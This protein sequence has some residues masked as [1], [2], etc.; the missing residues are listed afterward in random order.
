MKGKTFVPSKSKIIRIFSLTMLVVFLNETFFPTVAFALTGGPS[1][2]EVQSFEPVGTSNMV[3]LS[4]GDFTYNIPLM[5]VDG[6]PINIAYHSGITMDQEASWVGLG[7]NLNPGVINRNMR[8]IPDDFNGESIEK[9]FNMKPNTTVTLNTSAGAEVFGLQFLTL[10]FSLGIK[11]NN[12]NGIGL[13]QGVTAT[14]DSKEG[15]NTPYTLGLGLSSSTDDGLTITPSA[16]FSTKAKL[17]GQKDAVI[18]GSVGCSFNSRAGLSSLSISTSAKIQERQTQKKADTKEQESASKDSDGKTKAFV[19]NG[20]SKPKKIKENLKSFLA[21]Q[22]ANAKG[23]VTHPKFSSSFD[24]GTPT[25]TPNIE[26]SMKHFSITG[27]FT[28]GGEVFGVDGVLGIGGSFSQQKLSSP[29][30]SRKSFGYLYTHNGQQ[31]DAILDFNREKDGIYSANTRNLPITSFTSDLLSVSGQGVGGSYRFFRSDVGYVFDTKS[32]TSSDGFSVGAEIGVGNTAH[33]GVDLSVN[34]VDGH[35]GKWT[36]ENRAISKLIFKNQTADPF[37]ESAY[38]KEANEKSVNSD[39]AF[40]ANTGGY[41]PVR[42]TIDGSTRYHAKLNDQLIDP[43]GNVTTL[44]SSNT[45]KKRDKRNQSLTYLTNSEYNDFAVEPLTINGSV[46]PNHISEITALG[47]DG[48]RYIYG[49]PLYNTYQK[50]V[51]FSVGSTEIDNPNI[52]LSGNDFKTGLVDY[53]PA[54]DENKTNNKLGIDNYF[55][56]VTT[57]AYAHSYLLTSIISADYVDID[58]TRGP[59]DGDFGSYTKFNYT[60]PSP[61]TN[62]QNSYHWRI[63]V[64]HQKASFNEGLKSDYRDDKAS[65]IYG[66]KELA[67]L[68]NIITKNYIAKFYVSKRKDGLGVTGEDGGVNSIISGYMLRLDSIALFNKR[69]FY[70]NGGNAVAV[71]KVHFVYDYSLCPGVPNNLNIGPNNAGG[72]LTLK[73]IYFS[74]GNSF[75]A[76]LSPYEFVYSSFNPSYGPKHYD[77]W[78]YYKENTA[79]TYGIY[80]HADVSIY[81]DAPIPVS[82]FPYVEQGTSQQDQDNADRNVEAWSLKNIYLPSGG[83]I[84]VEYESDDYAFV[85]NKKAMQMIKIVSCE[86]YDVEDKSGKF[87]NFN[88]SNGYNNPKFYFE[89]APGTTINDYWQ[90]SIN[91]Y[92]YFRFLVD[93]RNTSIISLDGRRH[94][95]FVSGYAKVEDIGLAG[96]GFG[97]IM[98]EGQPLDD[99]GTNYCPIHKA[100]IQYGRLNLPRVVWG[101]DFGD[102]NVSDLSKSI[103]SELWNSSIVKNMINAVGGVNTT[104]HAGAPDPPPVATDFVAGKSWIRLLNPNK[105]KF[106][107]GS[108]VKKVSMSDNWSPMV[109]NPSREETSDY[110]QVY[111][112]TLEDGSSSGVASYEP[113]LGGDENPFRQPVFREDKHLLAPDDQHYVEEPFGESFFPSPGVVYSKVTVS[114]LPRTEV[115]EDGSIISSVTRHGTGKIVHEFYTTRDFPTITERTLIDPVPHRTPRFSLG[116]I[117]KFLR[118]KDYRTV[119]QG[120]YIE[121]NDMNGKP[122]TQT[123]YQENQANPISK[124]EYKYKK[125]NYLSNSFRLKNDC[126]VIYN[127]GSHGQAEIGVNYDFVAD[128][129]ES[130]TEIYNASA[131]VNLDAFYIVFGVLA[132]PMIWPGYTNERTQFRSAVTTKVVQRFGILDEIIN[133][134]LGSTVSVK[135]TAFDAETGEVL[136]TQTTTEFEDPVY[137]LKFPAYWYYNSMGPAYRNIG[138][139]LDNITFINGVA[140]I[141]NAK[142]YFVPGDE[143]ALYKNIGNLKVWVLEVNTNS[144]KVA[145]KNG[146]KP[147]DNYSLKVIRSGRRNNL[148]TDMAQIITKNNPLD[149]IKSNVYDN[150]IHASATEYSDKW[151][152]YCNCFTDLLTNIHYSSNPYV[153][154]T[155]GDWKPW[156]EHTYLTSRTQSKY[157]DNTNIRKDGVYSSFNPFYKYNNG[158]WVIDNSNWTYASEVTEWHPLGEQL[159]NR[160]ALGIYSAATYGYS[161]SLP[162]AVAGNAKLQ[163]IAFDNFEDYD[164]NPCLDDHFKFE[165]SNLIQSNQSHTGRNSIKILDGASVPLE[166][167]IEYCERPLP[168]DGLDLERTPEG[169]GWLISGED[170]NAPYSYSWDIISGFPNVYLSGTGVMV[171]GTGWKLRVTIEDDKGCVISE[172]FNEN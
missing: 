9:S 76:R 14:I 25:Y 53:F 86:G 34:V 22:F 48:A 156:K 45:R 115:A 90:M 88:G 71:K 72:K 99:N 75:K 144:I 12:Y 49:L 43:A 92:V 148:Q 69:D 64:D 107:G 79:T 170:G 142:Q 40:I 117:L 129:R 41:T 108:R 145:K 153:L 128:F 93:I 165:A 157:D 65:Y 154:G 171:I 62:I 118:S 74:Y 152:T 147:T 29:F 57:P 54:S 100:A 106:G 59:S 163:E 135:N 109:G 46:K 111:N 58:N 15:S 96:P 32:S 17:S 91:E 138:L 127:D 13:I 85:Q 166:R 5:E 131:N 161:Q 98:F 105:K 30:Q 24:F 63:P 31:L 133:T 119:S 125:S 124:I 114:N 73:K 20:A 3:D 23:I 50:E 169:M 70:A 149:F 167:D 35:T 10:E 84:T 155:T 164:F 83:V 51:T 18:G 82:E 60:K 113:L 56:S 134:D 137:T 38:L 2:P 16:S 44:S 95:E 151:K 39:P 55:S 162:T 112:Y 33:T 158:K 4:T 146:S 8:G 103:L 143:L 28:F 132:V 172:I 139:Q 67:Y 116:S 126:D 120:Y 168:C 47:T 122:R 87:L 1:Q 160:D 66:Q 159:E 52:R 89:L 140:I 80:G 11:Y 77:R 101:D 141:N 19:P 121:L 36:D 136:L 42:F 123:V 7:W 150:V 110:G 37:F 97:Y 102:E 61:A 78:G 68:D 27:R 94:P 104:L 130:T 21:R 81:A 6:Y 26:M